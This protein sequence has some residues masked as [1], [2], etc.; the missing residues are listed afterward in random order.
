MEASTIEKYFKKAEFVE[1]VFTPCSIESELS[2]TSVSI[3]DFEDEV[4]LPLSVFTKLSKAVFDCE[5]KDLGS[6]D[7]ELSTCNTTQ[8]DWKLPKPDF[9]DCI[10]SVRNDDGVDNDDDDDHDQDNSVSDVCSNQKF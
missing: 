3:S 7:S 4:D 9:I 2:E 10:Y 8:I 1:S 5:V 6:I